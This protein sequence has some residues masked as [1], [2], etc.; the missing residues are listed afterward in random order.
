MSSVIVLSSSP[1][2]IF[3]PSPTQVE[4]VSPPRSPQGTVNSSAV[5]SGTLYKSSLTTRDSLSTGF[6]SAK[7]VLAPKPGA[8]NVPV[9]LLSSPNFRLNSAKA[10][11]PATAESASN[12]FA[13]DIPTFVPTDH[14]QAKPASD[15]DEIPDCTVVKVLPADVRRK[16]K[17]DKFEPLNLMS[18]T[19]RKKNWTPTKSVE[20]FPVDVDDIQKSSFGLDLARV[21]SVSNHNRASD[22]HGTLVSSETVGASKRR[23]IDLTNAVF[24]TRVGIS[25][26]A[27]KLT[28]RVTP[29]RAKSPSKKSRTITALAT[30]NH[31]DDDVD[32]ANPMLQYLLSTQANMNADRDLDT[33]ETKVA[34]KTSMSKKGQSRSRL[35]SPETVLSSLEAQDVIFA[36]ASQLAGDEP[37][38][39]LKDTIEAIKQSETH[40]NSS[41]PRTQQTAIFSELSTTPQRHG[42][43]RYGGHKSLW[44]AATRDGEGALLHNDHNLE[45]P[46]LKD[47]FTGKDVLQ[48][49]AVGIP[50]IDSAE[51]S[52]AL[53]GTLQPGK[54]IMINADNVET[55][56][57]YNTSAIRPRSQARSFSTSCRSPAS[58]RT[59]A[60]DISQ[61][62]SVADNANL[63]STTVH[64]SSKQRKPPPKPNYATW[65]DEELKDAVKAHGFK[66]LRARKTMIDK[67]DQRWADQHGVD[68][69]VVKEATKRA[70]KPVKTMDTGDFLDKVHDTTARPPPKLKKIRKKR[71]EV[72]DPANLKD[73]KKGKSR[74][75]VAGTIDDEIF[76]ISDIETPILTTSDRLLN[77]NI[78]SFDNDDCSA[79]DEPPSATAPAKGTGVAATSSSRIETKKADRLL[80]PPPTMPVPLKDSSPGFDDVHILSP[81]PKRRRSRGLGAKTLPALKP[82]TSNTSN[83]ST[84]VP[85]ASRILEAIQLAPPD[86]TARN[87]YT[88]PTWHEKIL[89][90]DPIVLE[91]LTAWL[92]TEG[93]SAIGEDREIDVSEVKDW[94]HANGICCLWKGGWRGNK[95]KGKDKAE[96]LEE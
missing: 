32:H 29:A 3:A 93:F 96:S 47:V 80:T 53:L 23:K 87:H 38:A 89:L 43:Y 82:D 10:R 84:D 24:E 91:E 72:K 27:A 66:R 68:W 20:R 64:T 13:V 30:S 62:A 36:T 25:T 94:C 76:D 71:S 75:V 14:D 67:L 73:T 37:P 1:T 2:R 83:T 81:S 40:L 45:L 11:I 79:D 90:Y 28:P 78:L 70:S 9:G 34:K 85:L 8:E 46:A 31:L 42:V 33:F 59:N 92:N 63:P 26:A 39:L 21:F 44:T 52:L 69:K 16:K 19:S 86:N 56:S 95:K 7:H 4:V 5:A 65:T 15:W 22:K 51:D 18:A 77:A 49:Q 57:T 48:E 17:A 58:K 12:K 50:V 41:P 54:A 61:P 6:I 55:L 74:A 60:L 35:R 88:N